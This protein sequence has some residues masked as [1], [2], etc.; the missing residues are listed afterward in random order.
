MHVIS[1][2]IGSMDVLDD[3]AVINSLNYNATFG[4]GGGAPGAGYGGGRIVLKATGTVHIQASG[5][6][7]AEGSTATVPRLG[8]GSGGSIT[9][10]AN[11]CVHRGTMSAAGGAA[12]PLSSASGAAGGGG[13]ITIIV[14]NWIQNSFSIFYMINSDF[15]CSH[16][17]IL[18]NVGFHA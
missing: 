7:L 15:F 14:S 9:V 16:M 11:Q 4:S 8:A 5:A 13:R 18:K 2:K 12:Y 17:H 3:L 10:S 6:L 1:P